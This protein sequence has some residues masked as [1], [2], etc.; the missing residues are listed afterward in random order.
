LVPVAHELWDDEACHQLTTRAVSFARETG[1]RK[2]AGSALDP[3]RGR[4]CHG[5]RH[6][7]SERLA[8][9]DDRP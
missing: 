4:R 2:C 7:L 1:A 6:L 9:D 5:A 8:T 3:P